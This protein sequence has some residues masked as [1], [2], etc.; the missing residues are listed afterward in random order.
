MAFPIHISAKNLPNREP[1]EAI[2]NERADRL[3]RFHRRITSGRVAIAVDGQHPPRH[4]IKIEI[5]IPGSEIVV[6]RGP[7]EDL[8]AAIHEAFDVAR[9]QL[10]DRDP[11]KHHHL[12]E[13]R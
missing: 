3:E 8:A 1:L 9:R 2:I 12:S 13:K 5:A 10:Q 6:S 11:H 7:A 4:R